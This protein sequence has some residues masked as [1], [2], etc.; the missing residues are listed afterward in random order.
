VSRKPPSFH[1]IGLDVAKSYAQLSLLDSDGKQIRSRRFAST[2]E[3]FIKL[4]SELSP[5]DAVAL[6]VTINVASQKTR[7][8][9]P[10][11]KF[12][13]KSTAGFDSLTPQIVW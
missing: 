1:F 8:I 13:A 5:L 6:E 10:L 9:S 7:S 4:A 11:L 2:H 12:N 3:N